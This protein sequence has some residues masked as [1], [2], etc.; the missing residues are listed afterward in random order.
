MS[1]VPAERGFAGVI[2]GRV[3]ALLLTGP[4]ASSSAVW[5]GVTCGGLDELRPLSTDLMLRSRNRQ[6][7]A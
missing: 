7:A 1:T 2:A 5:V 4:R 6:R 3:F